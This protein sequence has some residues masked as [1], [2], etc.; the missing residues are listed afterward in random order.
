MIDI[1]NVT[2]TYKVTDSEGKTVLRTALRDFAMQVKKGELVVLTGA[3][4]CGKT[5]VIR[6]IN[7]LIP[8]YFTGELTGEVLVGGDNVSKQPVYS[9]AAKVGTVFQNP[10]NQFFNVD[11]TAELAFGAENM[12]R[13]PEKILSDIER[14]SNLMGLNELLNRSMFELSGGEK[15]RIACAGIGVTDQE[16]IVLD[17]P[18]SNLDAAGIE[19]LKGILH[20][21]K[22]MGK[23]I[24]IAEH[25]LYFLRN[26]ADRVLIL[27]EGVIK[28]ELTGSEF[29]ALTQD[30]TTALGIRA[31]DLTKINQGVKEI[32]KGFSMEKDRTL[33]VSNLE[34]TYPDGEHGVNIKE[35]KIPTESIVCIVGRNGQGKSTF[36][37]CLCGLNKKAKGTVTFGGRKVP[38]NKMLEHC[39]MV[40]QDVNHQL[41][42]ESVRDEVELS[43]DSKDEELC[44]QRA[45]EA[46]E[47][48][49]I[50]KFS[51]FH[52]M[53]LSGGQKQR[54]A[55]ACAVAGSKDILIL[56]EP[57]SGLDHYHMHQV[58][59]VL[60]ILTENKKTVIV[61]THDTELIQE[62]ADY[63]VDLAL[64]FY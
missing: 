56:D 15:Q 13:D 3:S 37:R 62:C 31:V 10:K 35:L 19:N 29:G 28:K 40:M 22:S 16:V 2:Y 44:R 49:D 58:A 42:T 18:T 9:T 17:E 51:E 6:L 21:W 30:E 48:L 7:G 43:V 20:M 23:T 52:P 64:S 4:G 59:E 8:H 53:A 14:I 36:A 24:V 57:T 33:T 34:F 25:R 45:D 50:R 55:I 60:K 63:V 5:S 61:I 1:N 32:N 41:F 27:E 26:L 12:A 39:F 46:M 38:I 11:S 54:V 47:L